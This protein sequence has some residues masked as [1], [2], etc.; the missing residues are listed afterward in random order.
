MCRVFVWF[1]GATSPL[2]LLVPVSK[3]EEPPSLTC[4]SF[5][6]DAVWMAALRNKDPSEAGYKK[7]LSLIVDSPY[8]SQDRQ[9]E[10]LILDFIYHKQEA[11][12]I[13]ELNEKSIVITLC[14][15][16]NWARK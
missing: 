6:N 2:F 4:E 3:A 1:F 5:G 13:D 10:E 15:E 11:G 9:L 7:G 16:K 12:N 8:T 14:S